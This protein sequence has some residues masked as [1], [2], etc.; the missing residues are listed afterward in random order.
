MPGFPGVFGVSEV[1]GVAGASAASDVPGVELREAME[2]CDALACLL[3]P[4]VILPFVEGP[5]AGAPSL[6]ASSC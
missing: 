5:C 2:G 4:D 3:G 6:T 1:P